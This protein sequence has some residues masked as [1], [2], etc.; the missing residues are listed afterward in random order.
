[1]SID[2]KKNIKA[3]R[4]GNQLAGFQLYQHFAKATYNTILRIVP[5]SDIASDLLQE[6]FIQAFEKIDK[7][8]NEQA[9]GGWIK[10]I[11]INR[12]LE[13]LRKQKQFPLSL[14]EIND[15]DAKEEEVEIPELAFGTIQ[16]AINELPAGCRIIFQLFYLEEYS[17]AEIANELNTSISNSKTQL[18]YAKQLLQEKLKRVY[19]T[20]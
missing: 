19:E 8:E 5:Q 14:E 7:L 12:S 17:H 9:F 6:S 18:R 15:F 11:A 1:M 16:S 3:L 20:R 2:L 10:R 4:K 13:H